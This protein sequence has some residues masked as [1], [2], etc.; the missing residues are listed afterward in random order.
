MGIV[1]FNKTFGTGSKNVASSGNT[2]ERPKAQ[3]WL[4]LG[5]SVPVTGTD[6]AGA[7]VT[8][9]RFVSLPVGIP[10]D[11][12]ERI[13]VKSSNQG[14]AAFQSARNDLLD[15]IMSAAEQL[16]PGEAKTLKL[17]IEL[18]RVAGPREAI[19]NDENPFVMKLEL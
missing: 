13:D 17:E 16:A 18:R 3:Y 7:E 11:T 15:Q 1:D 10:L 12:M 6:E 9:N 8:E 4:N 2:D 5:Y 19:K 14:F